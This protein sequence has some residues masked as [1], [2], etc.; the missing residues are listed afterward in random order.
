MK[1]ADFISGTSNNNKGTS[2]T[3]A[4]EDEKQGDE[5]LFCHI[6]C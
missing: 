5:D 4:D 3:Q 2:P 1:R 6:H